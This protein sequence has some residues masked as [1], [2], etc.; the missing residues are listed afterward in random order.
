MN[1]FILSAYIRIMN[2]YKNILECI[3]VS[4]ECVSKLNKL[5]HVVNIFKYN[6][7]YFHS[8]IHRL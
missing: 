1:G 4:L 6:V 2:P 5:E 7:E 8:I 3:F